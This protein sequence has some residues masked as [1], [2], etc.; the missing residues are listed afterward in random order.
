MRVL[1][2]RRKKDHIV[3]Y[4]YNRVS[5]LAEYLA[6]VFVPNYCFNTL[7]FCVASKAYQLYMSFLS[8]I[9]VCRATSVFYEMMKM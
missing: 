9:K 1:Y 8:A 2:Q 6:F 7:K 4:F 3:S 5:I